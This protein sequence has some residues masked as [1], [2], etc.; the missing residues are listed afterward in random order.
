MADA[1]P[2]QT[3]S[4][5]ESVNKDA[6]ITT[7]PN[8]LLEEIFDKLENN[9]LIKYLYNRNFRDIVI[10]ILLK[11]LKVGSISIEHLSQIINDKQFRF[12]IAEYL[13][14]CIAKEDCFKMKE[15]YDKIEIPIIRNAI[16]SRTP[17]LFTEEM[18]QEIPEGSTIRQMLDTIRI[19]RFL[20]MFT[21][22]VDDEVAANNGIP[23][24]GLEAYKG[25]VERTIFSAT[26]NISNG[27]KLE[28]SSG[29]GANCII[30][31]SITQITDR[32]PCDFDHIFPKI[33]EYVLDDIRLIEIFKYTIGNS[34]TGPPV[35]VF[36]L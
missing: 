29:Y 35:K 28:L 4:L 18:G 17:Q 16:E 32:I 3:L 12:K 22:L 31:N 10:N 23:L 15:I 33:Y 24:N 25:K 13:S 6:S 11:R 1:L 8:E 30:K 14:T 20:D 36:S 27:I 7:I 21:K 34:I 5:S 26:I 2:I 9:D 19:V